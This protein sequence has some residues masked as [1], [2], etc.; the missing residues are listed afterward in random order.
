MTTSSGPSRSPN[1]WATRPPW[2]RAGASGRGAPLDQRD[3]PRHRG[4]PAGRRGGEPARALPARRR[5]H[6]GARDLLRHGGRLR[7]GA[8]D[9]VSRLAVAR[10]HGDI[11]RTADVLAAWPRSRSTRPTRAPPAPT[12]R[13]RRHRPPRAADGGPRR[14]D[15]AGA[16]GG[17]RGRP[18]RCGDDAGPGPRAAEKIGQ[19]LASPSATG[20]PARWP[21]RAAA[22][23]RPSGC[24]PR[25]SGWRPRPAAPTSPSRRT[26]PAGWSG[27]LAARRRGGRTRVD[28]GRIVAARPPARPAHGGRCHCPRLKSV[29]RTARNAYAS[30]GVTRDL[31]DDMRTAGRKVVRAALGALVLSSM[32]I[33]A[34]TTPPAEALPGNC[35][36]TFN[37]VSGAWNV[38]ANWL[39]NTGFPDSSTA[40][41]CVPS[42]RTVTLSTFVVANQVHST[43]RAC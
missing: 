13:R 27:A 5:G 28:A 8:G 37:V 1:H 23:R 39:P 3:R 32:V 14:H 42:G 33:V 20:S 19:R 26:W 4:R 25:R 17:G 24:T 2:R 38:N 21:P 12:P 41:A 43:R 15:H 34:T 35:T 10:E 6:R 36:H 7:R 31:G 16:R 18:G 40:I 30:G 9:A 29:V 22:P 11:A